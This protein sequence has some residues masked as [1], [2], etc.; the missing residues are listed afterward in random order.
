MIHWNYRNRLFSK[1]AEGLCIYQQ[2]FTECLLMPG[3]L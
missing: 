2:I 1:A 3:I